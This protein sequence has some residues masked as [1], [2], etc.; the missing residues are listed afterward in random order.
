MALMLK[1]LSPEQTLFEGE[2][3]YINLPGRQGAF[4]VLVNHAAIVSTLAEG[5]V[6]YGRY[7]KEKND[8]AIM[9]GLVEVSNNEVS[10]CVTT[11]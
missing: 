8:L 11:K 2:I 10:L 6:T 9:S 4:E 7:K 3:D 5:I 1:I